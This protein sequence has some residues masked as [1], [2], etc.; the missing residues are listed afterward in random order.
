M[1]KKSPLILLLFFLLSGC[2]SNK[3]SFRHDV[4]LSF[5]SERIAYNVVGKGSI[6]LVFIHGWSCDGRYWQNQTPVF[7]KEY[8]VITVDLAGHGHSSL[9][10]S[11]FSMLSFANDVKA[12]IDKEKINKA[13]LVGHSMGGAVIAEAARLMPDKVIGII[14]V[15]TLQNI[16]ERTPQSVI[17]EMANPFEVDFNS[18]AQNFVSSMFV[19]N[20]DQELVSWVKEDMSSAPKDVA[21]S[22]FY[23]YLGQF[24]NGEAASVF[25]DIT[26]PVISINARLWET[27]PGENR[28]HIKNYKL[29]YI[30]ESG[31]FPMLEKPEE[32]NVLLKKSLNAIK[33]SATKN[34]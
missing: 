7:A 20:S 13:I 1:K 10:R 17:D 6:A 34:R 21:L 29:F 22:A 4:A 27:K 24:V 30:E 33:L 12:I 16:A 14:G 9:N 5:D 26:I 19:E 23:N 3:S 32:F 15:D 25:K 18:A 11:E 28:K 2:V 31:H 8:Q